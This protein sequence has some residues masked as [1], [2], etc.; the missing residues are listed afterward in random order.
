[1]VVRQTANI[2]IPPPDRES[3]G[4]VTYSSEDLVEK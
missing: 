1:M 4:G 2:P 3:Q